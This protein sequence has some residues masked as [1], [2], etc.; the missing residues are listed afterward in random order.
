VGRWAQARR[1]QSTLP[2]GGGLGPPPA[3][4]LAIA[5]GGLTQTAQGGCDAGGIIALY[6]REIGLEEWELYVDDPWEA[7][8]WWGPVEELAG[9][10]YR[11]LENGN[12]LSY[13]GDSLWSNELSI[14]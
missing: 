8:K 13:S 6:R 10:E 4:L 1:R 12:G 9:Y 2:T 11:A 3:P 7:V 5:G 14:D